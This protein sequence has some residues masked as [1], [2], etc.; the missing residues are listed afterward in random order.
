M[1]QR[2][3]AGA[4]V[5][6]LVAVLAVAGCGGGGGGDD[7]TVGA[8]TA[9]NGP[10]TKAQYIAA[11]DK[12]CKETFDKISTAATKL[13]EAARKTGTIPVTQVSKFLTQTSLPA[14]D[15][16]LDQLRALQPPKGDEKAIDGLIASLAGAIDTAKADPVKYSKN[17][18]PDPFDDAN[19]RAMRYGMKVCG[20]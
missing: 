2:K 6:M 7:T 13:R 11:A 20:S 15:Q 4:V 16:L 14:Y 12:V 5:W 18:A 8:T 9:G 10:L 1:Q 3:P 17:G 19:A